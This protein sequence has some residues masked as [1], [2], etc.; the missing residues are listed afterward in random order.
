[1]NQSQRDRINELCAAIAVEQDG[2]KFTALVKELQHLLEAEEARLRGSPSSADAIRVLVVDDH[3]IVRRGICELLTAE[4]ELEVVGE[5]ATG[6]EALLKVVDLQPNVVVLDISLPD[7]D[8]LEVTRQMRRIVPAAEIL[9]VSEHDAAMMKEA[10]RAGARGYL[11]KSD[12]SRE[13]APAVRTVNSKKQYI[14]QRF[15]LHKTEE[16]PAST[17]GSARGG[18]LS[19]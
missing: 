5:A 3:S 11:L 2:E 9:L 19:T 6:T 13:L 4:P 12:S 18:S 17:R 8:G 16:H 10:F 7:I 14:T 1:M 15:D